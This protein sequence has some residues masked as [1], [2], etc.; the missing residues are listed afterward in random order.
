MTVPVALALTDIH[1]RYGSQTAVDGLSL[2]VHR[3]EIVGLL[4]PNGSGKSSTLAVAAGVLDPFIGT[5]AIAGINRVDDPEGYAAH[6]GLVPQEPALYEELSAEA[7]LLFF[8]RLYGLTGCQL[9]HRV[10]AA[11]TRSRLTDRARDRVSRF[12]GGMKQRLNLAC[13]LLHNPSVLLLDEP[14]AALD[15][16]SRD[17]L[18]ADLHELREAGHAILLTTHHLDEA[19]HG[20]D[21]IVV[22]EHGRMAACGKASDLIRHQPAGRSIIYAHMR[23]TLPR[24]FIKALRHKIGPTVEIEVTGRRLRLA[25][26]DQVALG[27]AIAR[28]LAE[29]IILESFRTPPGR[30]DHLLHRPDGEATPAEAGGTA[31]NHRT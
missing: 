5:V 9:Q 25:A 12:S 13:A 28:V 17:A 15:P 30:L 2:A 21:R 4:G 10:D 7:N 3:G 14:T 18:F 24:F 16:A 1:V 23:E 26:A 20:C 6:V 19:E 27:R 11:L 31:G 8:G 22:L 29:G